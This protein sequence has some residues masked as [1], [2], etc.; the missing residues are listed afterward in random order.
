MPKWELPDELKFLDNRK[1]VQKT[2]DASM[3]GKVCVV[4]GSTSSLPISAISPTSAKL[5]RCS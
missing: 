2:T 4:S 5:P 1:A 3:A